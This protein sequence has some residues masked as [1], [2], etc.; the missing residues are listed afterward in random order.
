MT[1]F[2]SP[3]NRR[4][5]AVR[6]LLVGMLLL[7]GLGAGYLLS[8][9]R[10]APGPG[11]VL[12]CVT[13]WTGQVRY[14]TSAAQCTTGTVVEF[15]QQGAPGPQGPPGPQG[16]QGPVGPAG[17]GGVSG[18]EEVIVTDNPGIPGTELSATAFCPPGKAVVGGGAAV[19]DPTWHLTQSRAGG[20]NNWIGVAALAPGL[21]A[22]TAVLTVSAICADVTP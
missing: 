18:R 20:S 11:V 8:A 15:N 2:G 3:L 5:I 1:A 16:A 10:A 7:S 4:A 9:T 21:P 12:L 19:S 14:I 17:S 22:D 6:G 13:G